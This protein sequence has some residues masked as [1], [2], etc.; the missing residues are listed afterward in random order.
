MIKACFFDVDGTLLSHTHTSKR[1]PESTRDSLEKLR[2]KGIKVF[3][4]TGRHLYD[5]PKLPLEGIQFDGFV[6]LNGQLCADEKKEIIYR[7]PLEEKDTRT[8]LELFVKREEPLMLVAE[9]RHYLNFINDT[10]RR[11]QQ[12]FSLPLPE[13]SL[14]DGVPIYMAIAFIGKEEEERFW[15]LLPAG[16]KMTRWASGGVDII[17]KTSG[18][19][20]GMERILSH[21]G[22][23]SEE[24]MAFGDGENDT[25]MLRFAGIGVAMGNAACQVKEAADYVT[26]H[27]DEDGLTK[28]LEYFKILS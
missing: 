22:I 23:A 20:A 17:S 14:Y 28:A 15:P 3:V 12:E 25:D 16:C 13:P 21:Y 5:L 4:S 8:L 1:V 7:R 10:V 19:V 26:D 27:I 9:E 24:I 2:K 11:T 18:K 6:T